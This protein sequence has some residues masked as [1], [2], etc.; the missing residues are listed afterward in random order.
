MELLGSI[1]PC[2]HLPPSLISA[3][4]LGITQLVG[5]PASA[6]TF[7]ATTSQ[8]TWHEGR[9][10]AGTARYGD[11]IATFVMDGPCLPWR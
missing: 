2:S 6:A 11:E 8:R 7:S 9:C 5:K 4:T 1:T 10:F 3:E